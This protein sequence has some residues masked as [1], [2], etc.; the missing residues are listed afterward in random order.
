MTVTCD[1]C[2]KTYTNKYLLARHQKTAKKC[3]LIQGEKNI[4]NF[5]CV[6][7]N[8]TFTRKD[9]YQ[10]HIDICGPYI[11]IQ[12]SEE[13]EW[14]LIKKDDEIGCLRDEIK[15]LRV[16]LSKRPNITINN[17]DNRKIVFETH[18]SEKLVRKSLTHLTTKF[19][20]EGAHGLAKF[21][22]EHPYK[23]NV[24]CRDPSRNLLEYKNG[25]GKIV[26]DKNGFRIAPDFFRG[27]RSSAEAKIEE[28]MENYST[29]ITDEKELAKQASRLG[30]IISGVKDGARGE[31]TTFTSEWVASLCSLLYSQ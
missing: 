25:A 27:I 15:K 21:A 16:E 5:K 22:S 19:L 3:L 10:T 29:Y 26:K 20:D 31:K 28:L 24:I 13:Y 1:Y 18:I 2:N 7:C 4:P 6:G 12:L 30:D 11:E 14:Q 9:Y 8:S 23:G 17:N